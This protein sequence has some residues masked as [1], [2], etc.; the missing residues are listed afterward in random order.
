MKTFLQRLFGKEAQREPAKHP[1][2]DP[3]RIQKFGHN[4]V[5]IDA[6]GFFG[7]HEASPNGDFH[8]IWADR[9]PEGTVGGYRL[10]GHGSW[11]LLHDDEIVSTGRLERPADGKVANN[12][13]FIIHDWMFGDGLKGR[14][15]AFRADG[16]KLVEKELTANLFSNG[17]SADG[18]FAIC[19]TANAP[20]SEDGCRNLL[21]DLELGEEITRWEV[22][23]GW[24][25]GY[26]FD[27][28]NRRVYLLRTQGG[29]VGY[30]FDG[31]M[32]DR[33]GWQTER[34]GAGDLHVIGM[35]LASDEPRDRGERDALLA[36]LQIA[37]QGPER[38]LQAHAF[39]LLGEL[40]EKEGA[41]QEA[42]DA[43]DKAL[44][45]NPRIGVARRL[46]K[47]RKSL[48]GSAKGLG[49]EG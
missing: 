42:I 2:R 36:G 1:K 8:L 33:K 22:E 44:C 28:N 17:L 20:G 29:R 23:T 46:E 38:T 47:L 35:V 3:L 10:E 30:D 25:D 12:G 5:Q 49:T 11:S 27:T 34:I 41:V 21:F 15:I 14:F 31:A 13:S 40:H 4:L 43:Y 24:A 39:R 16:E 19:Q 32:L 6:L 7:H 26:E 37:A 9:N 48:P 45:I 18:R